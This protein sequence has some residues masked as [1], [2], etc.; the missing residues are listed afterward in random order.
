MA[1]TTVQRGGTA[2][3]VGGIL[4]ALVPVAFSMAH[5]EGTQRG[6]A[7]FI[8]V[9]ASYWLVGVLSLGLLMVG[10]GSLRRT[11]GDGAGRLGTAGIVISAVALP[12]ML[13]GNGTEMATLSFAGKESDLGHSAFLIG[14]L[15]LLVGSLLLG[16]ALLRSRPGTV[17]RWAAVLLVGLL[18]LG[19]GLAF[20][21]GVL[22]PDSD[23][24]FWAAITVPYG[25]SWV[26]LGASL[27]SDRRPATADLAPVS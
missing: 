27:R 7:S 5:L 3:M 11:L 22:A 14:F 9:A 13:L 25:I 12:A 23:A 19:F 26:L 16:I 15:L 21:G 4:W 20:L 17:V 18:P 10:L 2:A 1:T 8:A 24:G 6:T